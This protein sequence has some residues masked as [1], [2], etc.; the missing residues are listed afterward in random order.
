MQE[1]IL[2]II[3]ELKDNLMAVG[4]FASG[5]P[6]SWDAIMRIEAIVRR[7]EQKGT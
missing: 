3:Q 6:Y 1:E 7:E 4:C 5:D 2:K